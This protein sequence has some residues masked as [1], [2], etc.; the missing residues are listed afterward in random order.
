LY[1]CDASVFS[2]Y[3]ASNIHSSVVLVADIFSKRFISMDAPSRAAALDRH[4]TP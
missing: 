2:E 3:A 1:V 4:V